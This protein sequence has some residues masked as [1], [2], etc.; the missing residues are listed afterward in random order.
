MVGLPGSLDNGTGNS[1]FGIPVN[2]LCIFMVSWLPHPLF[3]GLGD[4]D[5]KG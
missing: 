5:R 1:K 4:V 2:S 3:V